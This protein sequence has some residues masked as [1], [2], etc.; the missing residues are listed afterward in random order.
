MLALQKTSQNAD[1]ARRR[2][3]PL[4]LKQVGVEMGVTKERVRQLEARAPSKL[5]K[6]AEEDRIDVQ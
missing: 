4:T 5:R 6:A 1:G 3:E 2:R